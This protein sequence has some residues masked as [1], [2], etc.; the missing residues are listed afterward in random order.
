MNRVIRLIPPFTVVLSLMIVSCTKTSTFSSTSGNMQVTTYAGSGVSGSG[1]G[2]NLTASF[3]SPYSLAIDNLGNVYVGDL[4]NYSVRV[5]NPIFGV[6][7]LANEYNGV[8]LAPSG[9]AVDGS[10]TVYCVDYETQQILKISASGTV[11]VFAGSGLIMPGSPRDGTGTAA[12]F[13]GPYGAALD[14][15]GNLYVADGDANMIRK[16]TPS[17]VVTTLAG[18]ISAGSTD[19]TGT[20]ASFNSPEGVAVNT[21]G[22]V[23]VADEGND[24]IRQITPSGVVTT[25][26]GTS[27][28][29]G[30]ADGTGTHAMF[31]T[32]SGIAVDKQGN[33]YVADSHNNVIREIDPTTGIVTTLAGTGY[34]GSANGTPDASSFFVPIGIAV[35]AAGNVYV[36]DSHNYLVRKI[37][38]IPN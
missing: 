21:Q 24:C 22:V 12:T 8:G 1:N 17:G 5:I 36:A 4:G 2:P 27:H 7:L 38:K 18:S 3:G 19:A 25:L 34:A 31:D 15:A 30:Y 11:T 35:D 14:L 32:P 6:S 13:G 16:I 37:S 20:A 28:T 29:Q 9:L 26:A 33:I 23:Y 10:G